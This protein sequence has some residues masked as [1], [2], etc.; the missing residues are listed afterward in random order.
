MS[1]R[2]G[3]ALRLQRDNGVV[4]SKQGPGQYVLWEIARCGPEPPLLPPIP[5]RPHRG[6]RQNW[7]RERKRGARDHLFLDATGSRPSIFEC[8]RSAISGWDTIQTLIGTEGAMFVRPI[9]ALGLLALVC[10]AGKA[11]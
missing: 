5:E 4:R 7:R 10:M 1:K 8:S 2:V 11:D 6:I 3:V 9:A